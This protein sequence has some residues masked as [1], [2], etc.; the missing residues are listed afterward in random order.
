[1]K[2]SVSLHA[3]LCA[4]SCSV[5]DVVLL[6]DIIFRKLNLKFCFCWNRALPTALSVAGSN[7]IVVAAPLLSKL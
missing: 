6:E 4:P 3:H 2:T 1:M 7:D 5:S